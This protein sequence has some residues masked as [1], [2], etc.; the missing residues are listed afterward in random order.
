M[1]APAPLLFHGIEGPDNPLLA[2]GGTLQVD[3]ARAYLH[4]LR[5]KTGIRFMSPVL[6][7]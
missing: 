4:D 1:H 6:A 2:L 3:Y 5:A 7:A